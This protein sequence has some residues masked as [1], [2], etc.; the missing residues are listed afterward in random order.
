[1]TPY[2]PS[3]NRIFS[4]VTLTLYFGVQGVKIGLNESL[5]HWIGVTTPANKVSGVFRPGLCSTHKSTAS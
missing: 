4:V 1:M 2:N 3:K 5:T